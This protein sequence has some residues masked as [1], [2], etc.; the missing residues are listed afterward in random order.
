M[1]A[2][3][4]SALRELSTLAGQS[5]SMDWHGRVPRSNKSLVLGVKSY[6][7]PPRICQKTLR[8]LAPLKPIFQAINNKQLL[9]M[10][11]E[12]WQAVQD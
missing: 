1:E 9:I 7:C 8:S 4:R 10:S 11:K 12:Y 6:P 2:W 5:S 3:F